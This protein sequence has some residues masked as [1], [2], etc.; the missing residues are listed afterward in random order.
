MWSYDIYLTYHTA[1]GVYVIFNGAIKKVILQS[2]LIFWNIQGFLHS[3]WLSGSLLKAK[4]IFIF[5][6]VHCRL[7]AKLI[8]ITTREKFLFLFFFGVKKMSS[9]YIYYDLA[10]IFPVLMLANSQKWGVFQVIQER[11][12]CGF[13][14]CERS[15]ASYTTTGDYGAPHGSKKFL[16]NWKMNM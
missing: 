14:M 4:G 3:E 12:E 11:M 13:K 10:K 5:A 2:I 6:H 1:M 15:L 16:S 9:Q 8:I 7:S